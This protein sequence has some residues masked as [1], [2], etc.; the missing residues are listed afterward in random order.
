MITGLMP[1]PG[2]GHSPELIIELCVQ[3]QPSEQWFTL[4]QV[5]NLLGNR[6]ARAAASPSG[7]RRRDALLKEWLPKAR[8]QKT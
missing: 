7:R 4:A 2:P 1:S 5:F 6:L 8:T 3:E